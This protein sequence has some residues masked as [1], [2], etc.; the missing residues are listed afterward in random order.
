MK[1]STVNSSH[2]RRLKTWTHGEGNIRLSEDDGPPSHVF[3]GNDDDDEDADDEP[4]STRAERLRN[5]SRSR[6]DLTIPPTPPPK[7]FGIFDDG[8][9]LV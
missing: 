5:E 4:L 1:W 7:Q 8:R 6:E 2:V 3:V 9:P